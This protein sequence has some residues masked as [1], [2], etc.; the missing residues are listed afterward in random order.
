MPPPYGPAANGK[1]VYGSDGDLYV[2]DSLDGE[3]RFSSAGRAT[4]PAPCSRFDG[5]LVAYDNVVDGVDHVT[6]ANADGSNP[7]VILDQPFTGLSAAWSPD[8]RSMVAQTD[9]ADGSKA[10]WIAA[11]DGSGAREVKVD[12]VGAARRDLQPCG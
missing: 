11:A 5:Q 2:R 7:H 3:P 4:R 10:L 6:V 1:I 9:N 8:S 12:G